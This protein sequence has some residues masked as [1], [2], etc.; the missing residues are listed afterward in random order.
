MLR[1][2]SL[3]FPD[4]VCSS[5]G[6]SVSS[7]AANPASQL[8]ASNSGFDSV[9]SQDMPGK[10]EG[11]EEGI[12]KMIYRCRFL[13]IFGVFGSLIGSFLCF[14]KVSISHFVNLYLIKFTK[15]VVLLN[16]VFVQMMQLK[17]QV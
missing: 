5:S 12:E 1:Y 6:T 2:K 13:A 4:F 11:I 7:S 9:V 3:R 10:H 8:V 14:I 16:R 15:I 17:K